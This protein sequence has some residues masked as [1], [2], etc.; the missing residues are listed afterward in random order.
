MSAAEK[1]LVGYCLR[2]GGDEFDGV[3]HRCPKPHVLVEQIVALK[4]AVAKT[5]LAFDRQ[6]LWPP[7]KQRLYDELRGAI[8]DMDAALKR[9]AA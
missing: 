1:K 6:P 5:K 7:S 2:C 4:Y 3:R 8:D 9:F